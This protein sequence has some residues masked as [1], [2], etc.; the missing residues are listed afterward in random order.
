MEVP[1]HSHRKGQLV[2]A[3]RG[4]ISCRVPNGLWIVPPQCAVWIPSHVEHSNLATANA[5]LYFVYIEPGLDKLPQHCCTFAISPLVRE[6]IF[7]LSAQTF[8]IDSRSELFTMVFLEEMA[9]MPSER[10]HLP[11]SSDPRVERLAR[12]LADDPANRASLGEWAKQLAMSESSFAR[13]LV[14]ETG[15]SFGRWRRQLHLLIAIRELASGGT[16]Q[17]VSAAL[18]YESASAFITMFKNALGQPP[19]RYSS[20]AV[21]IANRPL[22]E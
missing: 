2:Y 6:L 3:L 21:E 20:T 5:D 7:E 19:G 11:I 14:R 12:A 10:L 8:G 4:A 18:G 17:Q 1:V 13:L 15:L 9:R 22:R 16:V